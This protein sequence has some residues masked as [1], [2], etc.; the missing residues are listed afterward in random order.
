MVESEQRKENIDQKPFVIR[1]HHLVHYTMLLRET[2]FY[3][4]IDPAGKA[5][6]A[7]EVREKSLARLS[8]VKHESSE[9]INEEIMY[10]QDVIGLSMN[11]AE[12]FEENIK[13]VFT[14]FLS[15]PNDYP[16]DITEGIPDAICDTCTIGKHCREFNKTTNTNNVKGDGEDLDKFIKILLNIHLPQPVITPEEAHFSDAKPQQVRVIKTTMEVVRKVLNDCKSDLLWEA[17]NSQ[18]EF[19]KER[20]RLTSIYWKNYW[21]KQRSRDAKI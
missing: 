8:L 7:R 20:V 5:K 2:P 11:D 19:I 9:W 18:E 14:R 1:G 6:E 17:Q 15:L 3:P 12:T 21:K 4:Q 13:A 16:A 10:S